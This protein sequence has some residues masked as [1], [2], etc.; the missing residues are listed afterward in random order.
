MTRDVI[1]QI[2]K[3]EGRVERAAE[4]VPEIGMHPL[5]RKDMSRNLPD[6]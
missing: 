1:S 2:R 5:R 4:A 6:V 3:G